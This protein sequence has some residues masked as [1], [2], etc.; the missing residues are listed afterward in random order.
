MTLN[1]IHSKLLP[2]I[3]KLYDTYLFAYVP[4]DTYFISFL[5]QYLVEKLHLFDYN[6]ILHFFHS[7]KTT[8]IHQWHKRLSNIMSLNW[9]TFV[10]IFLFWLIHMVTGLPQQPL[11]FYFC[12]TRAN[13]AGSKLIQ[14]LE[15][16]TLNSISSFP[17][18]LLL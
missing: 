12:W 10:I 11:E 5:H 7:V 2:Q 16:A 15:S 8:E 13:S 14:V 1:S 6:V 17:G 9:F 3:R 4:M 18:C